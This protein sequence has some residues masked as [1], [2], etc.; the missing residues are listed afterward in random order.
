M[1]ECST[2]ESV[3]GRNVGGANSPLGGDFDLTSSGESGLP[4]CRRGEFA[5]RS[6]TA[7]GARCDAVGRNV[8][9]ANSPLGEVPPSGRGEGRKSRNV[10]GANSPLGEVP[11]SGRG[12][13]RKSRNVG[14]ANS[15]LG[16]RQTALLGERRLC[17]NVGGANSPL[18]VLHAW[19]YAKGGNWPQCRRGEFAPRS[20]RRAGCRRR[21]L[22]AAM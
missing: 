10:G 13:G 1:D 11:P 5:P 19:R 4:Q 6:R 18:G 17:R 12:E 2:P 15:P 3:R 21:R 14:G 20:L 7:A 8:G 9:G 16:V 22:G